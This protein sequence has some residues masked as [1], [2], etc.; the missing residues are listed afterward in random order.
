MPESASLWTYGRV[1]PVCQLQL[2]QTSLDHIEARFAVDR[3]VTADEE[4]RLREAVC[5][6]LGMGDV[7]GGFYWHIGSAK[8]SSLKLEKFEGGLEGALRVAANY[9]L[10][11]AAAV[12]AGSFQPKPPSGSC[13]G[14]CPASAFCWRYTPRA[15]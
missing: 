1:A 12:R 14:Y 10:A 2:V 5:D 7:S 8:A 4:Q 13:P 3:P 11:Y 9:A 6:A 15:W